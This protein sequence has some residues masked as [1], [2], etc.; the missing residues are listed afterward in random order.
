ML[1]YLAVEV[2][3]GCL[4][5]FLNEQLLLIAVSEY[6]L[7]CYY[8]FFTG[9]RRKEKPKQQQRAE[10][11]R[12]NKETTPTTKKKTRQRRRRRRRR[13]QQQ[14]ATTERTN[15][16]SNRTTKQATTAA[17]VLIK[18]YSQPHRTTT[19][20]NSMTHTAKSLLR[21]SLFIRCFACAATLCVW[22]QWFNLFLFCWCGR[23]KKLI[24]IRRKRA[25][26]RSPFLRSVSA[27]HYYRY[28]VHYLSLL[29]LF[30]IILIKQAYST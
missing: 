22:P 4:Y 14:T 15:S 13:R 9:M 10:R 17:A 21:R 3:W 24:V 5:T 23:K 29:L 26:C 25:F 11:W 19:T 18:V 2:G 16:S 27:S 20:I 28:D 1:V 30:W 8:R 7:Y 6:W 12:I